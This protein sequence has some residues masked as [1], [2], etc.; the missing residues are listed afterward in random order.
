MVD[1]SLDSERPVRSLYGSSTRSP[2]ITPAAWSSRFFSVV[3]L[4]WSID[5][6]ETL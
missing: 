3:A 5:K 4:H 2:K 1:G 6:V